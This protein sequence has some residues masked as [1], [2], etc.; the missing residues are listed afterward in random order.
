MKEKLY[1]FMM[2]RYG[3]DQFNRFL[4]LL[5]LVFFVISVFG[6]RGFYLGGLACLIYAYFRMLSRNTYKRSLENNRYLQY[7]S[8][9]KRYL[10]G[11]KRNL[12]QRKTHHIY[13]CPSCRQK[14]RIPR[15]KG[16]IEIRCPKC[17]Q[18]FIKKS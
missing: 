16:K 8:K 10:S 12:E 15:G 2:G 1:R 4:M 3:S 13:K 18:T 11:W 14:I 6:V 9:V 17:G 7:E 5:G